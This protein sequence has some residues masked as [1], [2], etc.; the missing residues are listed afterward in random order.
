MVMQNYVV[1]SP[2]VPARL[3]FADHDLVRKTLNDPATGRPK[4]LTSLVFQVDQIN[5]QPAAGQYSI[6][7]QKHS[8]DFGPYLEGK[9]YRDYDFTI[10]ALGSGWTREYRLAVELHQRR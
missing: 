1:L 2:G 5:G 10:T 6:V 7:S 8:N 3:H 9:R 4:E